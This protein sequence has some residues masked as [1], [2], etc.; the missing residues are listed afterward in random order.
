MHQRPVSVGAGTITFR[1]FSKTHAAFALA[2]A[3]Y[4]QLSFLAHDLESRLSDIASV[5]LGT[6]RSYRIIPYVILQHPTADGSRD[7]TMLSGWG[8]RRTRQLHDAIAARHAA[9]R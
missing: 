3:V 5:R 6:P 7:E 1:S 4:T 2:P 8:Q 9:H